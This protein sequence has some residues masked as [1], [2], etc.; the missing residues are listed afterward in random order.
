[1]VFAVGQNPKN[2]E[3]SAIGKADLR[4]LTTSDDMAIGHNLAR[5]DEPSGAKR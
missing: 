5:P 1:M 2:G 4:F 3:C